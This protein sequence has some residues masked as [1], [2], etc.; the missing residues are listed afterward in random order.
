VIVKSSTPEF[1]Y[2]MI[3]PEVFYNRE[4]LWQFPREPTGPDGTNS[5]RMAP[6]YIMMRLPRRSAR[7]ILPDAA[8]GAEP[9]GKHD[10]LAR[11]ALR[12]ARLR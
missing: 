3:A 4:D 5:A 10:R 7:R 12:S 9:A 2:N 11:R 8:D 6:Y 1:D